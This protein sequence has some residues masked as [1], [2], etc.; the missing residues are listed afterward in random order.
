MS[1]CV[2][3]GCRPS[4]LPQ[5]NGSWRDTSVS[6]NLRPIL[7]TFTKSI[8]GGIRT[9]TG[10]RGWKDD[11]GG[12]GKAAH[13][14]GCR[15]SSTVLY[16]V[17]ALLTFRGQKCSRRPLLTSTETQNCAGVTR[18]MSIMGHRRH[19]YQHI[20]TSILTFPSQLQMWNTPCSMHR[21]PGGCTCSSCSHN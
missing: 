14:S 21:P 6:M 9:P 10:K 8:N 5:Y 15:G 7:V 13:V 1:V 18:W 19:G 12:C 11:I 17:K 20:N 16:N 2:G 4:Q 3:S